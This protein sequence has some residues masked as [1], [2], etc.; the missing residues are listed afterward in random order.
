MDALGTDEPF[1]CYAEVVFAAA[2]GHAWRGGLHCW[3]GSV[4]D[5]SSVM[6]QFVKEKLNHD[7]LQARRTEVGSY[8]SKQD[9]AA[10]RR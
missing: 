2:G 5:L 1:H 6:G 7:C 4:L 10:L 3:P 9:E 8:K